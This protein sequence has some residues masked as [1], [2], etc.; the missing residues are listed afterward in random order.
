MN[1]RE[2]DV[3]HAMLSAA[4]PV[5]GR[6]AAGWILVWLAGVA[7]LILLGAGLIVLK[8][9]PV[10]GGLVGGLL[11]TAGI[12]CLYAILALISSFLRWRNVF[13]QSQRDMVPLIR[14]VLEEG[15]VHS[16][17]IIA[18]AVIEI[19]EFEDEGP[20]FIFD[21]GE[22]RTLLLKGQQYVPEG[23]TILWPAS[24]FEIVRSTDRSLWIG[25]FTEGRPLLPARII[26]MEDCRE[27]FVWSE[28]EAVL[29]GSP[30]TALQGILKPS[31]PAGPH[32]PTSHPDHSGI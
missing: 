3:L 5:S 22:G 4:S 6:S 28:Q 16:K 18:S 8:P 19:G 15:K 14:R 13:R 23:N 17:H 10:V 30:E 20:G 11:F 29:T 2:R 12:I 32:D 24:E 26:S 1:D 25:L 7:L 21:I 9:N 31:L 27:D